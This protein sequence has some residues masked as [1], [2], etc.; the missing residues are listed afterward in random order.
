MDMEILSE[1]LRR[2]KM[3]GDDEISKVLKDFD[4]ESADDVKEVKEVMFGDKDMDEYDKS[5]SSVNKSTD[6]L[7]P[8]HEE[9]EEG[10]EKKA[11]KKKEKEDEE[12]EAAKIREALKKEVKPFGNKQSS[13]EDEGSDKQCLWDRISP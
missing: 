12:N 7:A 13:V 1:I 2:R 3:K 11:L 5:G 6:E 8:S 10:K 9:T 4:S